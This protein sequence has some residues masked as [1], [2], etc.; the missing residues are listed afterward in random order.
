MASTFREL[1]DEFT[2]SVKVY[3]EKL[4]VT[5]RL[6]M[7]FYTRGMQKFQRETN[8]MESWLE[9]TKDSQDRFLAP[10]DMLSCVD[11]KD[12]DGRQ[13]LVVDY[14][15]YVRILQLADAD[16]E[17]LETPTDFDMRLDS[18]SHVTAI[19]N[20]VFVF[21][22]AYTGDSITVHYIPDMDAF[23]ENSSQW[24]AWYATPAD[25]ETYF[26]SSGVTPSLAPYEDAFLDFAIYRYLR[27][28]GQAEHAGMYLKLY[29]EQVGKAKIEKPVYYKEIRRPYQMAPY[30]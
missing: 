9:V 21:Y 14:E 16:G 27:T 20:R 26:N 22:P 5:E 3:T 10:N 1:Y 7:R 25:F 23:S 30:S 28:Q 13:M 29:N 4:D 11:V 8:Y 12:E 17:Y 18:D 2:D 19:W 24:A 6:F 15:Q